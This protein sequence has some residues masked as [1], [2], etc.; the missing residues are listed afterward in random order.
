MP[1]LA[2]SARNHEHAKTSS[3]VLLLLYEQQEFV[4]PTKPES[5]AYLNSPVLVELYD[6][7]ETP[8][9]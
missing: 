3:K 9:F 6:G 7:R 1:N 8:D 4:P 2:L 5:H